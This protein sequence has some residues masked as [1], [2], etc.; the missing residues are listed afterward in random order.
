MSL[1]LQKHMERMIQ[2]VAFYNNDREKTIQHPSL[3]LEL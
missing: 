3:H 2:P 1:K